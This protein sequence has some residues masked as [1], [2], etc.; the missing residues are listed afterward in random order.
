MPPKPPRDTA[1]DTEGDIWNYQR[2]NTHPYA[3][4]YDLQNNFKQNI[5]FY[6]YL[7]NKYVKVGT[8]SG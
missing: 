6:Y 1:S 7:Y 2:A 8:I 3:G 4:E 5:Y